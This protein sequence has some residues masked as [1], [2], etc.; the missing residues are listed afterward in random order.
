MR[1]FCVGFMPIYPN[2]VRINVDNWLE[3]AR[4]DAERMR[5]DPNYAAFRKRQREFTSLVPQQEAKK[6]RLLGPTFDTIRRSIASTISAAQRS[7]QAQAK[8]A[9]SPAAASPS[10]QEQAQQPQQQQPLQTLPQPP[11]HQQHQHQQQ[12]TPAATPQPKTSAAAPK[13]VSRPTYPC[14]LCPEPVT[15]GLV[16]IHNA[17][18]Q[19]RDLYAHKLCV[20]FTPTTWCSADPETG[21]ELVF[22]YDQI[23]KERWN[24]KCGLCHDKHGTKVSSGLSSSSPAALAI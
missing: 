24:L 8:K 9:Q 20:T 5:A 22:G 4:Q 14:A 11:Q 15:D 17:K 13:P 7:M 16:R 10:K 18:K 6:R 3:E 21:E 23:E 1:I 12:T 2:R 19:G